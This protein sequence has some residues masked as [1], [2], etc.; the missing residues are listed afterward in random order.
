MSL[1][2]KRATPT[3]LAQGILSTSGNLQ[4][5]VEEVLSTPRK[6]KPR[7]SC[8]NSPRPVGPM[9]QLDLSDDEDRDGCVG[10]DVENGLSARDHERSEFA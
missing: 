3:R 5:A 8:V 1:T 9:R 10:K 6:S 4:A 7:A 2:P